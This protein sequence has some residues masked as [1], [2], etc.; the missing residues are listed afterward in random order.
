MP[1]VAK[2]GIDL[3]FHKVDCRGVIPCA[4]DTVGDLG[5]KGSSL[6]LIGVA[7]FLVVVFSGEAVGWSVELLDCLFV[8]YDLYL[9]FFF[10]RTFCFKVLFVFHYLSL[11]HLLGY[12]VYLVLSGL[13]C[14]NL[15][16]SLG[17][18]VLWVTYLLLFLQA[19]V[20]A[21]RTVCFK[22]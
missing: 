11:G 1:S 19:V 20:L 14:V 7:F 4:A 16:F 5:P 15:L 3:L 9:F 12:L 18:F 2:Q 8:D 21:C 22:S 17:C 13:V 10:P 6:P